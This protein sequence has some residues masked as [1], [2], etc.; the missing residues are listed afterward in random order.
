MLGY[1]AG[2]TG[3]AM[4]NNTNFHPEYI[5]RRNKKD[6]RKK[7]FLKLGHHTADFFTHFLNEMLFICFGKRI[8]NRTIHH[9][10]KHPFPRKLAA[11]DLFKNLLHRIIGFRTNDTG[12]SGEIPILRRVTDIFAHVGKPPS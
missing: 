5:G 8:E 10:F 7:L 3:L 9:V 11:L 4:V 6:F 1:V 12:T 2:V